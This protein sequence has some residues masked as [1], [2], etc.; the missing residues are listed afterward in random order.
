MTLPVSGTYTIYIDHYGTTTG[1]VNLTTIFDVPANPTVST[2]VGGPPVTVTTTVPGQDATITFAATAGQQVSWQW[3]RL[4]RS[5]GNCRRHQDPQPRRLA[6]ARTRPVD[7]PGNF[8]W[9]S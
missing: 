7:G 8:F 9:T 6:P 3:G 4:T 2:T 1:T 5:P